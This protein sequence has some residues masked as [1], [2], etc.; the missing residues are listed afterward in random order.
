MLY[1]VITYSVER[2][3]TFQEV[4]NECNQVGNALKKMGVRVGEVVGILSFDGPEWV[5]SYFGTLKIGGVALGL[6]TLLTPGE[7]DYTFRDSRAR[8]L[9]VHEGLLPQVEPILRNNFV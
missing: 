4:S 7:Y 8:V 3:L 6:N 1:E 9:I 2:N 5:T